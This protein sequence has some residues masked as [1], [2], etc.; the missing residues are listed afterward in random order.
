MANVAELDGQE[1]PLG[2]S[3]V[4]RSISSDT[5]G[6]K[7]SVSP[8]VCTEQ[9]GKFGLFKRNPVLKA[10]LRLLLSVSVKRKGPGNNE[11]FLFLFSIYFYIQSNMCYTI[12]ISVCEFDVPF[13]ISV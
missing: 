6:S 2:K 1:P 9:N 13:D 8:Y 4:K 7:H 10:K 12:R 11:L 3:L 5:D